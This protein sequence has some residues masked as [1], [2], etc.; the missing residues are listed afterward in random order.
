MQTCFLSSGIITGYPV[1]E[2]VSPLSTIESEVVLFRNQ[3]K[4]FTITYKFIPSA[5]SNFQLLVQI[6]AECRKT[7]QISVH[8]LFN[9]DYKLYSYN[10]VSSN[11]CNQFEGQIFV[12]YSMYYP[13]THF[14]GQK[15]FGRVFIY[16]ASTHPLSLGL[17]PVLGMTTTAGK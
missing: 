14:F 16:I 1:F 13:P 5:V 11:V 4:P 10:S 6:Q 17:L 2:L 12:P 8:V 15:L 9:V 3:A 7:V